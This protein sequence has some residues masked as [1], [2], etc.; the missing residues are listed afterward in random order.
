VDATHVNWEEY[1]YSI[2]QQCPW[3]YSAWQRGE[4]SIQRW[5]GCPEPLE[6]FQARIYTVD[7]NR[8]R[9]KKLAG[10]LDQDQQCEWLWSEPTYG[11]WA[12]AV[13]VLIQQDRHKLNEIRQQLNQ[14][15]C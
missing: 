5:R 15:K 13:P 14:K 3:S 6:H 1:F 8:R 10:K 7:L 9:L 2:K 12:T 4:I 11:R